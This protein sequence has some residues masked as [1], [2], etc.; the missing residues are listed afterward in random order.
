M[1]PVPRG[2]HG[3]KEGCNCIETCFLASKLSLHILCNQANV[4]DQA[5]P[6][7]NY[8]MKTYGGMNA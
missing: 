7:L 6:V 8:A 2:A 1:S 3:W 5:V 4:K